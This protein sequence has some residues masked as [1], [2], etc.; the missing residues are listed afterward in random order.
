MAI[1]RGLMRA[2]T[3]FGTGFLGGLA[4]KYADQKA[5]D[6]RLAEKNED[7]DFFIKEQD[8]LFD[9]KTKEEDR[10]NKEYLEGLSKE[11]GLPIEWFS[12]YAPHIVNDREAGKA[13]YS[14]LESE[15]GLM[16]FSQNI[17]PEKGGTDFRTVFE[18]F[19][20]RNKNT[21]SNDKNAIKGDLVANNNVSPNVTELFT[22]GENT[23]NQT[24][25][26]DASTATADSSFSWKDSAFNSSLMNGN[27][28]T[29][30]I[31]PKIY[32]H[33][34]IGPVEV[35][36]YENSPGSNAAGAGYYAQMMNNEGKMV[37]AKLPASFFNDV[38]AEGIQNPELLFFEYFDKV[39][40]KHYTLR[41]FKEGNNVQVTG[42]N[43]VLAKDLNFNQFKE[44]TLPGYNMSIDYRIEGPDKGI[45][46]EFQP[47]YMPLDEFEA[48]VRKGLDNENITFTQLG[49]GTA[50]ADLDQNDISKFYTTGIQ[51]LGLG[52]K[53]K[54]INLEG[55]GFAY[56]F[57]GETMSDRFASGYRQVT[58][59][60][61]TKYN[62]GDITDDVFEAIGLDKNLATPDLFNTYASSFILEY[63]KKLE[64]AF[65]AEVP[66]GDLTQFRNDNNIPS[67]IN[68]EG[69]GRYMAYSSMR[70]L[71]T[72]E[73]FINADNNINQILEE[74]P[75]DAAE[76]L[77]STKLQER[78]D[79]IK[80]QQKQ[81]VESRVD[82]VNKYFP[83]PIPGASRNDFFELINY[84]V[85]DRD[86]EDQLTNLRADIISLIKDEYGD[87]DK[88]KKQREDD[89]RLL[90]SIA[91]E[92]INNNLP[93]QSNVGPKSE[94]QIALESKA[95]QEA[96]AQEQEQQTE[97][98]IAALPKAPAAP[99]IPFLT[100]P[101][102]REKLEKE[103][104]DW[105]NTYG[106]FFFKDGSK[107]T[108]VQID[109]MEKDKIKKTERF[110]KNQDLDNYKTLNPD[111]FPE[112]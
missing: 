90:D 36:Q 66:E 34:L 89:Y 79:L 25:M 41:G 56:D 102:D 51:I 83:N 108:Q 60:F 84:H 76:T 109:L 40:K 21:F 98:D 62:S 64:R 68:R 52:G 22:E 9:Q 20:T 23:A 44:K 85:R 38:F 100:N 74:E 43:G 37:E 46:S 42:M 49:K 110:Y 91:L 5:K 19:A 14:N 55:G 2:A 61:M 7:F 12:E 106:K 82:I 112:S 81:T 31:N 75:Q 71:S 87:D 67:S 8:Y 29:R 47:F 15:F 26:T 45:V 39:N 35:Y 72:L 92:Y 16:P 103:L 65:N 28:R 104:E 78:E 77:V 63:Q 1:G 95:E 99:T 94:G 80:E 69:I 33:K 24:S 4:D 70:N 17:H 3:Q 10:L 30:I 111:Y 48:T 53:D 13:W 59:D 107:K 97:S 101:Q 96:E 11:T 57:G 86:N 88:F 54:L 32:Y 6:D 50:P 58:S 93:S 73:S 18:Y 27:E 105:T